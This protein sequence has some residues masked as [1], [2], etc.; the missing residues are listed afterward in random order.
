MKTTIREL[1]KENANSKNLIDLLTERQ[2]IEAAMDQLRNFYLDREREF[3][4]L[5]KIHEQEKLM[6]REKMEKVN[7]QE[8]IEH[9][10]Q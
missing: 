1:F 2:S 10:S 5:V 7:M 3:K 6:W 4:N 8:K 9:A